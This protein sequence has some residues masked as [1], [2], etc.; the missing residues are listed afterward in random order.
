MKVYTSTAPLSALLKTV[1]S[2]KTGRETLL[3][4]INK[5]A[6]GL[7]NDRVQLHSG[8]KVIEL[9]AEPVERPDSTVRAA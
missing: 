7:T 2:G 5:R 1:L 3:D 6:A 9:S 8:T 4:L